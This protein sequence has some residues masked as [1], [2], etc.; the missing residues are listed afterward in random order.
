ML[1]AAADAAASSGRKDL[2]ILAVTVL[3]SI[4]DA[5]L[6]ELGIATAKSEQQVLRLATLAK[7]AGCNGLVLSP[8]EV[9]AAR[10]AI[11]KEMAIVTP[12]IRPTESGKDDQARVATASEAIRHG[13][14][15]LVIGRPIT[16][17]PDPLAAAQAFLQE[18]AGASQ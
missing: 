9:L 4:S 12:G 18:I 8:Q 7:E 17:A 2:I 6:A 11:G 5:D 15:H 3:T 14:S 10:E 1:S 13:A 16:A